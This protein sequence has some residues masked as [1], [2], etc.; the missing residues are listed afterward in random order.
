MAQITLD[1]PEDLLRELESRAE[2]SSKSISD[3]IREELELRYLHR[4]PE[5]KRGDISDRP[6]VQRAIRIQ[7]E[8][9]RK[10]EGSGYN[11]T[12]FIRRMRNGGH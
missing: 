11:A 2:K 1:L 4:L 9:R 3:F 8:S 10:H 7:D 6:E 12:E 5:R